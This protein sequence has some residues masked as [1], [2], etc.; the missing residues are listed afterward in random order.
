M[1]ALTFRFIAIQARG[2]FANCS[3]IEAM[4]AAERAAGLPIQRPYK[5]EP[6]RGDHIWWW[7]CWSLSTISFTLQPASSL[8]QATD[9]INNAI[10]RI[11]MP[12]SIHGSFAGTTQ[13][14]QES[15][16]KE[17][18]L[19]AAAI[20]VVY[21]LLGMLYESYIHPLTILSTLLSAGPH[22]IRHHWHDRSYFAD[23]HRHEERYHDDRCR[24]RGEA[25]GTF[26][27]I[28]WRYSEGVCYRFRPI[29][30]TTAAA[31]FGAVP[32]AMSFGNGCEIRRPL[33][34]AI[35][36]GLIVSRVM[37]LPST[38]V[39]YLF[40]ERFAHWSRR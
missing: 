36:G 28:R 40:M 30:M 23:R 11:H 24:S 17:P 20:G 32:L 21:I 6:R 7:D 38:P 2:R 37:T 4:L 16:S 14:F 18:I 34:L 3:V 19:I 1:E 29:L 13:L 5:G 9:E 31:I 10:A 35:V 33:D 39:L 22:R 8:G 27:F 26:E 12:A 15:L 25:V